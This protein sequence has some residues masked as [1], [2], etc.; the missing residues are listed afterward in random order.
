MPHGTIHSKS[1]RSV[2]TF[3]AN[4]CEVTPAETW[5]PIAAI[6]FSSTAPFGCVQTPVRPGT[7]IA[8]TP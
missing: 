8:A 5:I 6:F 7:R 4:P 1:L 3:S 2:V